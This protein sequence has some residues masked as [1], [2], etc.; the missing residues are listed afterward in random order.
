MARVLLWFAVSLCLFWL[1]WRFAVWHLLWQMA[2]IGATFVWVSIGCWLFSRQPRGRVAAPAARE[3][4]P[5]ELRAR[6]ERAAYAMK[7]GETAAVEMD[8]TDPEF[9][10]RRAVDRPVQK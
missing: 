2:L 10:I 3:L 1:C 4:T 5:I 7:F 6:A 8:L 9:W